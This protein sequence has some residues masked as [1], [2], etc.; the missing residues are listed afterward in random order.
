MVGF[1]K[2]IPSCGGILTPTQSD[3]E[4][5]RGIVDSYRRENVGSDGRFTQ[6]ERKQRLINWIA[7]ALQ[8]AR[9][10]VA[11]EVAKELD[12]YAQ[13]LLNALSDN[14]DLQLTWNSALRQSAWKAQEK[15]N[16]IRNRGKT[17]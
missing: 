2:Y 5:A 6:E 12:D 16:S 7:L 15:A 11:R 14:P 17:Q 4:K 10:E 1:T 13:D 3:V 8:Q 9:E